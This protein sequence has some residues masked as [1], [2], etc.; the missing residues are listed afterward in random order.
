MK[1][2]KLVDIGKLEI[3]DVSYLSGIGMKDK[4]QIKMKQVEI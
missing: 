1:V 2:A 4:L 3:I